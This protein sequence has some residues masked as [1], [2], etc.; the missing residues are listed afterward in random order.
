MTVF[1]RQRHAATRILLGCV[2][3]VVISAFAVAEK[4]QPDRLDFG[5]VHVGAKVQGSVRVLVDPKALAS[6]KAKV[7]PPAFAKV[8]SVHQGRQQYGK[9]NI[10]GYCDIAVTIDTANPGI[11]SAPIVVSIGELRIEVPVRADIRPRKAGL[12]RVLVTDTPF[13]KYS[14]DDGKLFD[15]WRALVERGGFDVDYVEIRPA[16]SPLDGVELAKYDTVLLGELGLVQLTK[17]DIA[18]LRQYAENGGRIILAANRFFRGTVEK[19]NMVLGP[20]GLEI[21]DIETP[22]RGAIEVGPGHILRCPQ[23]AGVKALS[24]HRPSPGVVLDPDRTMVLVG[25]PTDAQQHFVAFASAGKGQV[26]SLG[27]SLWWSWIAKADNAVLLE[28][29]LRRKPRKD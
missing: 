27:V 12:T 14:T 26:I 19:A 6:T 4:I 16:R 9:G 10:K 18:A 1:S 11:V 22:N 13:Q 5:V 15:P 24:F 23:T 17:K 3:S 21:K 7:T 29:L 28:N 8:A 25:C 20:S 2:I